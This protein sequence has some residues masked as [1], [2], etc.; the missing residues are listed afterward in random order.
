MT[1]DAVELLQ[2]VLA[3]GPMAVTDIE[4]EAR[5]ARLLGNEQELSESKPFRSARR[6]LGITTHKAALP[7]AGFGSSHRRCRRCHEQ[8]YCQ[9][10]GTFEDA[11]H[12]RRCPRNGCRKWEGIF[13]CEL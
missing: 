1:S 8:L 11:R 3:N 9:V 6:I 5:G 7:E 2:I 13:G 12:L 10:E 4:R